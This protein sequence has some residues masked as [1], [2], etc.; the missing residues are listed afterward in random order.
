MIVNG[1]GYLEVDITGADS[2]ETYPYL[3]VG[4]T[5]ETTDPFLL[6]ADQ[7]LIRS[8]QDWVD[9]SP[10][11]RPAAYRYTSQSLSAFVDQLVT[12]YF[13]E[14]LSESY[15]LTSGSR[16]MIALIPK[17]RRVRFDGNMADVVYP[18]SRG[19][20]MTQPTTDVDYSTQILPIQVSISLTETYN[21]SKP[22]MDSVF[23]ADSGVQADDDPLTGSVT[24]TK[25]VAD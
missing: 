23:F 10:W 13:P 8:P 2:D 25:I 19:L 21:N 11:Y 3:I 18:G 14:V 9:P 17:V 12:T 16:Y 15:L 22:R 24:G 5:G 1:Q 20:W 4:T 7:I 6:W